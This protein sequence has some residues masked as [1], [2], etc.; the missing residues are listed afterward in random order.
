MGDGRTLSN[1]TLLS[2]SIDPARFG[3]IRVRDD[4]TGDVYTLPCGYVVLTEYGNEERQ[5]DQEA[6]ALRDLQ[7]GTQAV[8]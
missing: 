8:E 1:V 5:R 7:D 6:E 3:S 2:V 4:N